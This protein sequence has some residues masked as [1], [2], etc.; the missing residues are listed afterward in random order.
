MSSFQ[1]NDQS[2]IR[3]TSRGINQPTLLPRSTSTSDLFAFPS[4]SQKRLFH[5]SENGV[6]L[7]K[8]VSIPNL[9]LIPEHKAHHRLTPYQIQ[10][11]HMKQ[12]FQ[13]PNGESF[14]P[15]RQLPK[16]ASS[17][18]L[19]RQRSANSH[20]K[21][22]AMH[23]SSSMVTVSLPQHEDMLKKPFQLQNPHSRVNHLPTISN[24]WLPSDTSQFGSLTTTP[25]S[26]ARAPSLSNTKAPNKSVLTAS[27]LH[28]NRL[29]SH[30]SQVSIS[31]FSN[32]QTTSSN[33]SQS[34]DTSIKEICDPGSATSTDLSDEELTKKILSSSVRT[35]KIVAESTPKVSNDLLKVPSTILSF[36]QKCNSHHGNTH[37]DTA[38]NGLTGPTSNVS[39]KKESV[40]SNIPISG[41]SNEKKA[42]K[43]VESSPVK[44]S[45]SRLSSFFKKLFPLKKKARKEDIQEKLPAKTQRQKA[46][47]SKPATSKPVISPTELAES[48]SLLDLETEDDIEDDGFKDLMDIDLVFDSLLLK[49]EQHQQNNDI[50]LINQFNESTRISSPTIEP[51]LRSSKRPLLVKDYQGRFIHH[52][53][54]GQTTHNDRI[55]EHL[56][57]NWKAVHFNAVVPSVV[58]SNDSSSSVSAKKCRFNEE[59]YVNDTFSPTEYVRSDKAFPESRKQL[60]KSRYIDGIKMELNEFKKREMLVHPNSSQYTH[61][62]L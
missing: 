2:S 47:T 31:S 39:I 41:N 36:P 11:S 23:R 60:L 62:F 54:N 37:I 55:I 34:T 1:F 58:R 12:S 29:Q 59:I 20:P 44:R 42:K 8:S 15:R 28:F 6:E 13:F 48:P 43:S 45:S 21:N 24:E 46:V 17:V 19:H 51:P 18:S 40:V 50:A 14:T 57:Q 53:N 49:S 27:S 16:S 9:A 30:Q 7:S 3:S 61:F 25:R 33:D 10:R 5:N 52:H 4:H 35:Q 56:H 32:K 22:T 38:A 26:N